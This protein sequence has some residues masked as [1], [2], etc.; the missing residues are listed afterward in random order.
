VGTF[1][2]FSLRLV[3]VFAMTSACASAR[4]EAPSATIDPSALEFARIDADARTICPEDD[5]SQQAYSGYVQ[6]ALKAANTALDRAREIQKRWDELARSTGEAR[7]QIL[8]SARAG[9]VFDCIWTSLRATKP[10][11]FT[12]QQ[13]AMLNKLQGIM[14]QINAQAG[15]QQEIAD[16]TA[17]VVRLKWLR[18][19]E[20]YLSQSAMGMVWLVCD[21]RPP[22]ASVCF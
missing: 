12:V 21:R 7:L 2:A 14:N 20:R 10:I 22:R 4:R 13:Q 16:N 17:E 19:Q 11:F 3:G 1:G 8:T 18:E 9:R 15:A 6:D 5:E